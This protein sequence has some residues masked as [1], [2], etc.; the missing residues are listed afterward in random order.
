[1]F[2]HLIRFASPTS[3]ARR[4]MLAK[5][6]AG[7]AMSSSF[8][9]TDHHL[10]VELQKDYGEETVEQKRSRLCYQSRKRGMLENGLLL[11]CFASKYLAGF[12]A[13]QLDEYD[14]LINKVSNEWDL[15]YWAVGKDQV[16]NEFD[17]SVFKLLK[18]FS[19]NELKESRICQ[20]PLH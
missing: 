14:Y 12:D 9:Q 10:T 19:T 1:M 4:P 15:Y 7:T 16:P 13:K 18:E 17:N 5:C 6:R 2:R 11:G 8:T 20:P 3:L